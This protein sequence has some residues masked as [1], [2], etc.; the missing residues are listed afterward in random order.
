MCL[1]PRLIRNKKYTATIKNNGNIPEPKDKRVLA[2]P[3]KCGRC[4]E[5]RKA[6]SREWQTRLNEEVRHNN[7]GR[8]VTLTISNES[9]AELGNEIEVTGYERDNAIATLA[10]RRF[11]E[12]WR[13]HEGKS[14][15]HWLITELGHNGTENVHLHGIVWNKNNKLITER[16]QYG[17]VFCGGWLSEQTVNYI[18]KYVHKTDLKHPNYKPKILTSKGIGS[19]YMKR[20]DAEQNKFKGLTTVETYKTRS[21][22]KLTL[23]VYYR[24]KIYS[25]EEREQLWLQKLDTQTRYV[26]KRKIDISKGP[27]EYYALLQEAQ[28][29]SAKLG[30][31]TDETDWDKKTY[32][33]KRRDMLYAE[34]TKK[35]TIQPKKIFTYIYVTE[36]GEIIE[37][38]E[39]KNGTYIKERSQIINTKE[40]EI[41]NKTTITKRITVRAANGS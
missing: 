10:T 18:V 3:L 8:F 16:W 39:V 25:E 26:D 27:E 14:V 6:I 35:T 12:R 9:L 28:R 34:R 19:G 7:K 13:K 20:F 5:C 31:G 37:P 23:P 41:N 11:L 4:M 33:E 38:H 2:V 32:E 22:T 21:G 15:K 36:D 30:Y 1:Y 40:D 29:K 24:N 17:H